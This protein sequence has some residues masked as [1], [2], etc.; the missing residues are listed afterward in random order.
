MTELADNQVVAGSY[1]ASHCCS[2]LMHNSA[3]LVLKYQKALIRIQ[4][5]M[6]D[7]EIEEKNF[8]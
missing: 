4:M 6:E 1:L 5:Q 2:Y 7:S 8:M 3:C